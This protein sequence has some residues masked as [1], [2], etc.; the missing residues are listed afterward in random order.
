MSDP[1]SEVIERFGILNT[2]I[3]PS[4][5][6]WHGIPYP[7]SYVIDADGTVI[8]KFFESRLNLRASAQDLLRAATGETVEAQARPHAG[9]DAQA[10][11]AGEVTVDVSYDGDVMCGGILRDLVV[12]L[13]VP[14]GQHLYS[15]PAPE[16]MVATAVDIDPALG[17]F[18][19]PAKF[20]EPHAHTLAGTDE[21]LQVFT[22]EVTIR[23]PITHMSRSL[24]ETE[25]GQ[26]VQR[27]EGTVN[28][29]S[30]DD[31]VCG[32]PGSRRFALDI[33][34]MGH[35][36]PGDEFTREEGMNLPAH[37]EKMVTRSGPKDMAQV[38]AE[39]PED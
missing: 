36:G 12:R 31:E 3:D 4:D 17:L 23:V 11:N 38:M 15:D 1:E 21:V 13:Q 6:P 33:P 25:D 7:G 5:H 19:R 30:C 18:V 9:T 32:L 34:A 39:L 16:G 20:P 26:M 35:V 14:A 28:W 24:T 10:T 22:G 8:A 37:F 2:L 29:Q 27:V